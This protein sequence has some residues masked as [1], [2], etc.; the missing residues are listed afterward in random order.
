VVLRTAVGNTA[1]QEVARRA[2]FRPDGVRRGGMRKLD[3][4]R[5]D[6]AIFLRDRG[7]RP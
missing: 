5:L 1:S 2:G 3:G 6:A 4:T 7:Q